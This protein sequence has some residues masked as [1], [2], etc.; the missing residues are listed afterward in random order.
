MRV[1]TTSHDVENGNGG[2]AT[3]AG[4]WGARDADLQPSICLV[5]PGWRFTSGI[6]YYTCLFANSLADGH[7]ASVIQLR[8]LIPR[9]LYPG[10]EH[11][12]RHRPDAT[13]S[14]GIPVFDGV[15]WWWGL[16][17]ARSIAFMRA[18]RP[19]V[20]VMQWW[21]AATLHT[22]LV[23][24]LVARILGARVVLDMHESQDPGEASFRLLRSVGR[25]GLGLLMRVADGAMVHSKAD[26]QLLTEAYNTRN[27][28][29]VVAPLGPFDQYVED[30]DDE[31]IGVLIE[32]VKSAPRPRVTN[33]L[34]FGL[35]RPYKGL[36]DLLTAF[37]C[38][39]DDEAAEFWLTIVGET[40]EL[41]PSRLIEASRR[42]DRITLVNSYVP[43]GVV[44]AAF[45]HA[46][47]VVL[48][49]RRSSGSATLQVAMS[50]GLP[51]V[52]TDVGGLSEAVEDY[53][54]AVLVRAGD[55]T[56]LRRGIVK[57][58]SMAGRAYA[59]PRSWTDS[60]NALL[61]AAGIRCGTEQRVQ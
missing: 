30:A 51:V 49:Y 21:T 8:Q 25:R 19:R 3:A 9:F 53:E 58:R 29:I 56:E 26:Q 46:D 5:G 52:V 39:S 4:D 10:K 2:S 31:S 38:M 57:A 43:D 28:R 41:D 15:N 60:A 13:Y 40:W 42:R 44:A 27:L 37:E 45:S 14:E 48:P 34:F 1:A 7:Q 23:L 12:A 35:I 59:N 36:E 16:S 20:V 54:G 11:V 24:A 47:V 6:S 61:E 22:Y 18:Q 50:R 32:T 17:I 33:L 55:A